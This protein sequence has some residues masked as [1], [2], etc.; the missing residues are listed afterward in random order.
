MDQLKRHNKESDL[1]KARHLMLCTR[2]LPGSFLTLFS[3]CL[4]SV[5]IYSHIFRTLPADQ[6]KNFKDVALREIASQKVAALNTTSQQQPKYRD[7]ASERRVLHN[8]PDVPLPDPS[9]SAQRKQAEGPP[10]PPPPPPPPVHPGK[11][12]NNVGNKLLK[13]MGWAEGS[14]LGTDGDGRVDPMYV[15]HGSYNYDVLT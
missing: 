7:R 3:L 13:K 6:Q 14:G 11:D 10:L 4:C 15:N 8:Q 2:I 12:E 9:V 5:L 1:H